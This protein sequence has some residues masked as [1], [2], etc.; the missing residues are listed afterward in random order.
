M[1]ARSPQTT[2]I[3]ADYSVPGIERNTVI[4]QDGT[5]LTF[6]NQGDTQ[7]IFDVSSNLHY[8]QQHLTLGPRAMVLPIN[9]EHWLTRQLE[10]Q[11]DMIHTNLWTVVKP[12]HHFVRRITAYDVPEKNGLYGVWSIQSLWAPLFPTE[13]EGAIGFSMR[14]LEGPIAISLET[15][16]APLD[17][18][19]FCEHLDDAVLPYLRSVDS[20]ERLYQEVKRR[21]ADAV[22]DALESKFCF[23]LAMGNFDAAREV[24]ARQRA[25]WFQK[26]DDHFDEQEMEQVRQL[27]R[28]LDEGSY[29]AI[30]LCLHEWEASAVESANLDGVWEPTRFPFEFDRKS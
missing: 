3:A 6:E 10:R 14:P 16:P 30:A 24:A 5:R 18:Q 13:L 2:K 29:G 1:A 28:F 7:R 19:V 20:M 4:L 12:V 15:I 25:H 26:Q 21:Q 27:C 11:R 23:D 9:R 8:P 22:A 17:Y